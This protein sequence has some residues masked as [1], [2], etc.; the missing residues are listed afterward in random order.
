MRIA[1][2]SD[3]HLINTI[4]FIR[5]T[6]SGV[7]IPTG[8]PI[9]VRGEMALLAMGQREDEDD[10]EGSLMLL[11]P[12]HPFW[13]GGRSCT[14]REATPEDHPAYSDLMREAKRRKLSP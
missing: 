5:R 9:R 7:R 2:M 3:S 13:N 1:D 11:D 12:A 4:R 14:S 8:I 6:V 10:D